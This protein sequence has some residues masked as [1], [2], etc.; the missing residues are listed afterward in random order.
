MHI[1]SLLLHLQPHWNDSHMKKQQLCSILEKN[2]SFWDVQI[3]AFSF[4]YILYDSLTV[5]E[6]R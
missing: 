5:S 1:R 2:V 3:I 6:L 4:I